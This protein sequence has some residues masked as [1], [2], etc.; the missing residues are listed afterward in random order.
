MVFTL[1]T[2]APGG[3]GVAPLGALTWAYRYTVGGADSLVSVG[4]KG[5]G[6][7][8]VGDGYVISGASLSGGDRDVSLL[9]VDTTGNAI[10]W[11]VGSSGALENGHYIFGMGSSLVVVGNRSTTTES[12]PLV[13]RFDTA[14]S[15]EWAVGIPFTVFSLLRVSVFSASLSHDSSTLYLLAGGLA[16]NV[17]YRYLIPVDVSSGSVGTSLS[18]SQSMVSYSGLSMT[19]ITTLSYGGLALVGGIWRNYPPPDYNDPLVLRLDDGLIPVW[20]KRLGIDGTSDYLTLVREGPGGHITAAGNRNRGT[21]NSV[22]LVEL[23]S[24]AGVVWAT[25]FWVDNLNLEP[26]D[27]VLLPDGYLLVG[28]AD[29][30]FPRDTGF[31]AKINPSGVVEFVR[32]SEGSTPF[33]TAVYAGLNG[34]FIGD[35]RDVWK[36]TSDGYSPCLRDITFQS[37]DLTD[38]ISVTDASVSFSRMTPPDTSL[39]LN[40]A[41]Q[42]VG[43]GVICSPLGGDPPLLLDGTSRMR[44]VERVRVYDISGR[45]LYSGVCARFRPPRKGIFLVRSE[46]GRVVLRVVR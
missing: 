23:D 15:L 16:F 22:I 37:K 27:L 36:L 7:L 25:E 11:L 28:V 17:I 34:L 8:P 3:K 42:S 14:G 45:L 44:G 35:G 41:A 5:R 40:L 30:S 13:F 32:L 33:Y 29:R 12:W 46:D 24:A 38:S 1:Y 43:R 10:G 4:R 20:T 31:I 9:Y 18:H 2:I 26:M 19:D 6:I 21:Y 39:S